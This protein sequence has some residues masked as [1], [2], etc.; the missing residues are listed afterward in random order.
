MSKMKT[1]SEIQNE[2]WTT[3][4]K[5]TFSGK[6]TLVIVNR[7]TGEIKE[8]ECVSKSVNESVIIKDDGTCDNDPAEMYGC[9]GYWKATWQKRVIDSQTKEAEEEE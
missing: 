2:I 9:N 8:F 3:S 5:A 4:G 7:L 1:F 6:E